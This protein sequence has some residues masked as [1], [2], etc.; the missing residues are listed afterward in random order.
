MWMN[1]AGKYDNGNVLGIW[2]YDW[3]VTIKIKAPDFCSQEDYWRMRSADQKSA[4]SET[5]SE[6]GGALDRKSVV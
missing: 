6:A 5:N 1:S 2:R 3:R 4:T